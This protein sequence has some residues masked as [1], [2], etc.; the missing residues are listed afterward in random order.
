MSDG[1]TGPAENATR[2]AFLGGLVQLLQPARGTGHRAG[3]DAVYLAAAVDPSTTGHVLDLG[4]G[5]GAAGFCLA[6]RLPHINVSLVDRDARALALAA[7]A[8]ELPENSHFADRIAQIEADIT[9]PGR[10]RHA[11]GLTPGLADHVICNPPYYP[12]A[13]FR[14]SPETSRAGAHVLDA[15]GLEPWARTITDV[16]KEGGTLTLIFRADGLD[17]VLAVLARRFGAIDIVPLRPRAEAPATR[18]LVRA[19]RASRAPLRLLPGFVLHEGEG[20]DFTPLARA[21][22]RD[23]AGLPLPPR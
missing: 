22:M 2:D 18:I 11:A 7:N 15:R 8:L 9:G 23:G 4:S 12:D 20:S 16:L 14:A 21:I 3:L 10:E 19:K 17:E 1:P 6:A 13:R 5:S